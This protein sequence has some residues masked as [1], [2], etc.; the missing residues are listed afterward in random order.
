MTTIAAGNHQQIYFDHL[1]DIVITPG[2]GGT[3]KFDCSTPNSA[4]TRPTA[5]IIYSE[6][7]ISIPAGSTVFLDAVGADATYD[8]YTHPSLSSLESAY[9]ASSNA[10]NS[11]MVGGV[12][13]YSDGTNWV[14]MGP[15]PQGGAIPAVIIGD[16]FGAQE[17]TVT[18]SQS[19]HNAAGL[20]STL[21]GWLGSPFDI[22]ADLAT[23]GYTTT[24]WASQVDAAAAYS[25]RALFLFCG[26]TNDIATGVSSDTIITNLKAAYAKAAAM[27]C[28][29]YHATNVSATLAGYF[30]TY[31]KRSELQNVYEWVT[32]Q[33]EKTYPNVTVIDAYS[34]YTD[35]ANGQPATNATTDNLH[36]NDYG[37]N[38]IL[39]TA[40]AKLYAQ[41]LGRAHGFGQYEDYRNLLATPAAKGAGLGGGTSSGYFG[42]G[43]GGINGGSVT[44]GWL[45][46]NEYQG[47]ANGTWSVVARTD[48]PRGSWSRINAASGVSS[49]GLAQFLKYGAA[50]NTAWS[51][52]AAK[53]ANVDAVVPT[54]PNGFIYRALTSGNTG[55]TQP[56]W[57]TKAGRTVV[58]GGVTWVAQALPYAGDKVRMRIEFRFPNAASQKGNYTIKLATAGVAYTVG[59]AWN[60]ATSG[61]PNLPSN[62]VV[63][64]TPD[65]TMPEGAVNELSAKVLLNAN[66]GTA[67]D[68]DVGRCLI[69]VKSRAAGSSYAL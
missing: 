50:G 44:S 43:T 47:A 53:T 60:Q 31:A 5:R 52:T 62:N 49:V 11:E 42:N 14:A 9:P 64:E 65:L 29:V 7:S 48:G 30:D 56:A 57:P 8:R 67:L 17:W 41:G 13:Y 35:P 6:T 59:S 32:T 20:F 45:A 34:A 69:W 63:F 68:L 26:Y 22:V 28:R 36:P 39:P 58:D 4:A 16:S 38:L 3:V 61:H 21:N 54:V 33:A 18:S 1:D 10:G 27:G 12:M 2:S 55:S 51:A 15:G 66:G 24:L 25:P 19:T 37:V 23:S 46:S 40:Y